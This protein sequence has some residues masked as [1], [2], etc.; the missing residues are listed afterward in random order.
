MTRLRAFLLDI[1]KFMRY[2]NIS[3]YKQKKILKET[4]QMSEHNVENQNYDFST[5]AKMKKFI[6]AN[7]K[8]LI[9]LAIC[10]GILIILLAIIIISAATDSDDYLNLENFNKIQIGMTY[11]EVVEVLE[12][13]NGSSDKNSG[14]GDWICTWEDSSGT[15][16]IS[17]RFDENGIVEKPSQKGLD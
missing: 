2:Y 10:L 14:R 3:K 17:V 12:N 1:Y 8:N 9:S 15:R 13:H 5:S 16:K 11:N 6:R 7:K 4:T